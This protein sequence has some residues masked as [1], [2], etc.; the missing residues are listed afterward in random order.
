[1]GYQRVGQLLKKKIHQ[2][3]SVCKIM[4]IAFFDK[5]GMIYEHIVSTTKPR[6]NV[7]KEYYVGVLRTLRKHIQW[8]RPEITKNFILHHDNAKP[9]TARFMQEFLAECGIEVLSHPPILPIW[10][11]QS[12]TVSGPHESAMPQEVQFRPGSRTN[13]QHH[14]V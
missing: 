5:K 3:K 11:L 14:L 9:H 7:T 1:M 12:L 10:A 2:A 4:L 6:T 8:K 13:L